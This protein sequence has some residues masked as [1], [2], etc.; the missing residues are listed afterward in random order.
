MIKVISYNLF[1]IKLESKFRKNIDI[2][3]FVNLF[4]EKNLLFN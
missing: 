1:I 3:K 4:I 2:L